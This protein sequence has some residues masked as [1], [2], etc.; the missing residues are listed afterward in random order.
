MMGNLELAISEL[1]SQMHLLENQN[2]IER[3]FFSTYKPEVDRFGG[4]AALNIVHQYFNHDTTHWLTL[5]QLSQQNPRSIP[6]KLLLIAVFHNLFCHVF[7]DETSVLKVWQ[8][9][10]D[11]TPVET[12]ST[13]PTVELLSIEELRN[14]FPI[15]DVEANILDSYSQ[16]HRQFAEGLIELWLL[17]QIS[18]DLHDILATTALFNFNR[19]GFPGERSSVI[20]AAV[21]R[22][23]AGRF[24][25]SSSKVHL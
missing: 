24:E 6:P 16:A 5:D 3:F 1:Y 18:G 20:V 23:L 17:K 14:L 22:L 8:S 15:T 13:I 10:E 21:S 19:H 7:D 9:L 12:N 25:R 2:F 4:L 11:L